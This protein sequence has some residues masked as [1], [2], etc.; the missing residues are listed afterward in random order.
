MPS[1][2]PRTW[3]TV[4][5]NPNRNPDA[6]RT[7][8]FGPGETDPT[9]ANATSATSSLTDGPGLQQASKPS[10]PGAGARSCTIFPS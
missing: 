6:H 10:K 8:L 9:N 5:R 1:A 7:V 4:R 3:G 2:V